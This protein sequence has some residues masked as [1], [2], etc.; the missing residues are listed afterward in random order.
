MIFYAKTPLML[1]AMHGKIE[2]AKKLLEAG[3]NVSKV[4]SFSFLFPYA[5]FLNLKK[6]SF[7]ARSRSMM[8]KLIRVFISTCSIDLNVWFIERANLFASRGV[9]RPFGLLASC[10]IRSPIHPRCRFLVGLYFFVSIWSYI[11]LLFLIFI[12]AISIQKQGIR[13]VC[14][15]SR[16][17]RGNA[18]ASRCEARTVRLRPH[19][20]GQWGYC[21]FFHRRIWVMVTIIALQFFS[22]FCYMCWICIF[23]SQFSGEYAAAFGR[24]RG[25]VRLR[26]RV[27]RVGRR[28]A[29]KRCSWVRILCSLNCSNYVW[30]FTNSSEIMLPLCYYYYYYIF[31]SLE[32]LLTQLLAFALLW[33]SVRLSFWFC[34]HFCGS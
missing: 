32:C 5:M 6:Y 3:A 22:P 29:S 17:Q 12:V 30:F 10:S 28:S 21:F 23:L 16:W 13:A 19:S 20:I 8:F 33:S 11:A 1:S 27:A 26:A 2:C 24:P 18:A 34:R 25:I 4:A 15:C 7:F 31:D 14:K 9:L